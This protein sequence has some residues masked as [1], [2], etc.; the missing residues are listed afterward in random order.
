MSAGLVSICAR[1]ID[2]AQRMMTDARVED[3]QLF[4]PPRVFGE[5]PDPA[6]HEA[7]I[8]AITDPP[9]RDNLEDFDELEPYL[10]RSRQAPSQHLLASTRVLR[11]RFLSPTLAEVQFEIYL[12][13]QGGFPFTHQ[14]S[15]DGQQWLRS[16]EDQAELLRRGGVVVPPHES[17]G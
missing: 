11:V 15:R 17:Q 13:G 2:D 10:P 12:G 14:V 5:E 9:S 8:R 16:R 6:A 3:R 7:V 4:L 1:C